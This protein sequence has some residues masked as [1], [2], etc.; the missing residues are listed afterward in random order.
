[1][2]KDYPGRILAPH[3]YPNKNGILLEMWSKVGIVGSNLKFI[4]FVLVIYWLTLVYAK[5]FQWSCHI[6]PSR[7]L[8]AHSQLHILSLRWFAFVPK[9]SQSSLFFITLFEIACAFCKTTQVT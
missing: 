4:S 3:I 7:V 6:Q 1:M 8:T 9:F 5:H 2:C